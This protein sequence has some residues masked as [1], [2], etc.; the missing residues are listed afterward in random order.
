MNKLDMATLDTYGSYI[1]RS[2]PVCHLSA[3]EYSI[4]VASSI[5]SNSQLTMLVFNYYAMHTYIV[6]VQGLFLLFVTF[7]QLNQ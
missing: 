4:N 6:H 1:S 5:S 3:E 2:L 7:S